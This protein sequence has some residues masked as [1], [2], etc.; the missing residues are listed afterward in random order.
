MGGRVAQRCGT[1]QECVDICPAGAYTG[2]AFRAGEPRR[3]RLD[4]RK[5]QHGFQDMEAAG[6]AH[7][8]GLRLYT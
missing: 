2:S 5:C 8:C 6:T 7:V 4:A 1:C 3:A